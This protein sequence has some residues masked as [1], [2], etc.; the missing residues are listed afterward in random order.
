MKGFE[1]YYTLNILE[2][3]SKENKEEIMLLKFYYYNIGN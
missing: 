3:S 2:N 1:K